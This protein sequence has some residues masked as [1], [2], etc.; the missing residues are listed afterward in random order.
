MPFTDKYTLIARL[1]PA[2]VVM[3]PFG[4]L[5]LAWFP[6]GT[7]VTGT[8]WTLI[9]TTGGTSLITQ[10]GRDPGRGKQASLW[11][12]WGGAPTTALLRHGG[13]ENP[14]VLK[15]RHRRLEELVGGLKMPTPEEEAADPE[16]SDRLYGSAVAYLLEATRD[17]ERFRLVHEENVNYGFRRNLWALR[18]FGIIGCILAG[19]GI[20]ALTAG[21]IA[22]LGGQ[23]LIDGDY[24]LGNDPTL[25]V[26]VLATILVATMLV[27]WTAVIRPTWV[28][29][30][31]DAYAQRL[32]GATDI[33]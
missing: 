1:Q 25:I 3:L 29:T 30:V 17:R 21:Q 24:L 18:P 8:L 11:K 28:K 12:R 20:V 4:L 14:E 13:S 22:Q 19:A 23:D 33:L 27:V 2:L 31:A 9:V 5:I 15:R 10:L 16:D 32:I 26:R 6:D 7:S